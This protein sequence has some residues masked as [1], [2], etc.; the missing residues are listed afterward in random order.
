MTWKARWNAPTGAVG[1]VAV[2]LAWAYGPDA[3]FG[4]W[5][6]PVAFAHFGAGALVGRWWALL[7]P[8]AIIVLCIPAQSVPPNAE[9][10]AFGWVLTF[11]LF[12]GFL[13]IV[14]GVVVGR[15][16]RGKPGFRDPDPWA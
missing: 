8:I 12:F 4:L 10:P 11:E 13:L 2:A 16:L 3:S 14:A 1:L 9:T 6:L 7:L 5:V 15:S